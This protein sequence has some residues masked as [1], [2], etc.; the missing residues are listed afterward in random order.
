V[1]SKLGHTT[2][3]SGFDIRFTN[4]LDYAVQERTLEVREIG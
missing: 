4:A 3:F 1:V 2:C